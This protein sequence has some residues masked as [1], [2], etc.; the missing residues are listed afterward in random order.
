MERHISRRTALHLAGAGS[1]AAL[2]AGIVRP[3]LAG[4]PG[5][6]GQATPDA[7]GTP[8]ALGTPSATLQSGTFSLPSLP[9]ATDALAPTISDE[10][11]ALHHGVL[12]NNYVTNLNRAVAGVP[13]LADLTLEELQTSL[14]LVPNDEIEGSEGEV[15]PR[16][17]LFLLSAGGHYNHSLF[18]EIMSPDG[19][20]EP[21][22]DV[23]DAITA[24]FGDFATL[25]EAMRLAAIGN[26]G[27]GWVWL[28][29]D[30]AGALSV[31]TTRDQNN[32]LTDELGYPVLGIDHW[33]H[34]Y[35]FDYEAARGDY[36]DA[37]W[38]V[39]NWERIN[40]RY[41]QAL[42]GA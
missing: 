14:A 29:S 10:T 37:W 4:G 39:A 20:G 19:G 26:P 28:A 41:A 18:W 17:E 15:V 12:H 31:V 2:A 27:S 33:E 11:M 25:Q 8:E 35:L 1:A 9:Y 6:I 36:I 16:P 32:P 21:T 23:G 42:E 34:A 7:D 30:P 13:D 5:T 3:G 40:E 22:G 38:D 24:A